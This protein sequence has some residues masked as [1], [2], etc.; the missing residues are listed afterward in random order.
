M[1]AYWAFAAFGALWGVWGAALPQIK[2]HAEVDDGQLGTALLFVAAG[3]LPAMLLTGR[4]SDRWGPRVPAAALVALGVAGV[5]VAVLARGAFSLSVALLL[6]GAASGS[7]DVAINAVAGAAERTCRRPVITFSHATF[8]AAVVAASLLTGLLQ[9]LGAPLWVAFSGVVLIAGI[10]AR[11]LLR[12][13]PAEHGNPRT[14]AGATGPGRDAI[15]SPPPWL[16]SPLLVAVGVVAALAFAVENAHQ[17]WGAI[18]LVDVLT[19]SPALAAVA[20][21]LFATVAAITRLA[22]GSLSHLRPVVLL[23]TGGAV[24]TA[25]T[26]L[27]AG[28]RSV[29]LALLGLACAAAGTAVL[30]PTLLSASTAGVV[31][32][33]RGRVTS[34]IST[35]AYLG[36]L[37]GPV[38]VG[39][40]ADSHGLR[41]AML[42]V[43]AIAALFTVLARPTIARIRAPR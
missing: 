42:G 3:A 40:L 24:A 27:L 16:R 20:P 13:T 6:L 12:G 37:C 4:A 39:R 7:A 19:V 8:S 41:G 10:A 32:A 33:V 31:E 5:L 11:F 36:F 22:A 25:G 35:T 30:F 18:Y 26:V 23:L 15:A 38:I 17:S 2:A 21:A 43:A 1:A 28:S 14:P 34:L 9:R 29:P